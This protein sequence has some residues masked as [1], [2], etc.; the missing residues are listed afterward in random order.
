MRSPGFTLVELMIVVAIIGILMALAVP[1]YQSHIAKSKRVS[2]QAELMQHAQ[3]LERVY[4]RQGSYPT[5]YTTSGV[6]GYTIS[7]QPGPANSPAPS[8][9]TITATAVSGS[10]QSND[11]QDGTLCTPLSLNSTGL[12]TPAVCW[13]S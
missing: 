7:Y 13:G 1:V 12:R 4:S 3:V 10:T 5:T 11:R 2:V 8:G 9:Y 6:D